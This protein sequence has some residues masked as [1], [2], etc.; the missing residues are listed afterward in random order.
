MDEIGPDHGLDSSNGRIGGGDCSDEDNAPEICPDRDLR[1]GKK[2]S[3][4][5]DEDHA[6]EVESNTDSQHTAEEEYAARHVL[7]ARAEADGEVFVDALD[8]EFEIRSD[9]KIRDDDAGEDRSDGKLRV[10]EAECLVALCRCAQK[11]R[12]AGLRRNDRG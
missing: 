7:R 10:G 12:R 3:P 5:H 2:V 8:F 6:T 4:D 9:E 1:A 11:C